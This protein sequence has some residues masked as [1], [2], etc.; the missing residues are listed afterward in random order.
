MTERAA[1]RLRDRRGRVRD[2]LRRVCGR[3]AQRG[4]CRVG[5]RAAGAG[6]GLAEP[7]QSAVVSQLLPD[8]L[9]GSGFGVLGAVQAIGDVVA[10]VVVGL[11][12]TVASPLVAFGYAAAWMVGAVVASGMLRPAT[13]N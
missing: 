5:V 3:R 11:L 6:I 4:G 12:Y 9:R 1:R 8:R 13:S 10:T 2:R 7:T